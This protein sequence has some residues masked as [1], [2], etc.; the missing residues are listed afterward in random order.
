[1]RKDA[2]D[3]FRAGVQAVEPE[4]AVKQYCRREGNR[5]LVHQKVYDLAE[6]ERVYVIGAGKAGAPM[7][8]AVEETLGDRITEG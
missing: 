1:M 4:A 2:L 6:F 3:I 8:R 5:L 7:A